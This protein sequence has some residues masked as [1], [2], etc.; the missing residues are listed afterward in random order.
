MKP[1]PATIIRTTNFWQG[2]EIGP[3]GEST[4]DILLNEHGIKLTPNDLS[5]YI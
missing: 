1:T 4:T 3:S 5:L 2:T